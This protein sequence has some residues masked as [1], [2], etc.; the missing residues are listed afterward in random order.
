[1]TSDR[2]G[3]VVCVLPGR[4]H[5]GP[6]GAVVEGLV[7]RGHRV[8]VVTGRKYADRF[9]RLGAEVLLMPVESDF[10]DTDLDAS[11]PGRSRL[12]GLALARHDL[13]ESF[14]RP[15]P[16]RWA[17]LQ[18]AMAEE[19]VDVVICDP[20]FMA[21]IPLLM[22]RTRGRPRVHVL[23]FVPLSLPPVAA[24]GP[25]HHAREWV[26]QRL[27]GMMTDPVQSLAEQTILEL[28]GEPLPC[29]F[30][31][32]IGMAD[33]I[34]QMTCPG[35]E[36]PRPAATVPIR[37]IGTVAT[38]T[39]TNH[40]LPDWWGDLDTDRPVVHVTQGTVANDTPADLIRPAIEAL[41]KQ[42]VLVVVSTGGTPL[43]GP[44]PDNVRIADFLPYD[45]LLPRCSLMVTNGGYGGVNL[46][47]RHGV[48]LLVVGASE[49]KR[50]VAHRVAW[51]G[52][53]IG[54]ARQRVSPRRLRR[55]VFRVLGEPKYRDRARALAREMASTGGVAEVVDV[56]EHGA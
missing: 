23:G 5:V 13:R 26:M 37:Y 25:G 11:F 9:T 44:L 35:F 17:T 8:R 1:M 42:D 6:A 43:E 55:A 31:D 50:L 3:I 7:G 22:T 16:A 4:G 34:F 52:A 53:G 14:V 19:P 24:P 36:Y 54:I 15:I 38:S 18:Q 28:T 39:A 41:A 56:V 20:V 30:I 49:D 32:W 47:L 33:G 12:H 2:L 40:P 27:I 48:P 45:Q 46:A 51:S 10:D 21:G 29:R